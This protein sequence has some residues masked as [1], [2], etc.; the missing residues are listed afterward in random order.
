[1]SFSIDECFP[2]HI[3]NMDKELPSVCLN[4]VRS[5]ASVTTESGRD[6]K[7]I[8]ITILIYKTLHR[9]YISAKEVYIFLFSYSKGQRANKNFIPQKV[10]IPE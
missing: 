2:I 3:S 5:E 4:F 1:M 7:I 6:T 10:C 9:D 8:Y